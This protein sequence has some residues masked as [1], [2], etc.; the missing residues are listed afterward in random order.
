MSS[1]VI[2]V[3][4]YVLSGNRFSYH[5]CPRSENPRAVLIIGDLFDSTVRCDLDAK[6]A[7]NFPSSVPEIQQDD[8]GLP[9]HFTQCQPPR[10][11]H[12]RV[13]AKVAGISESARVS[14]SNQQAG[15][16]ADQFA[17]PIPIAAIESLDVKLK[18]LFVLP[19]RYAWRY[20]SSFHQRQFR[21]ATIEGRLNTTHCRIHEP[22]DF[23]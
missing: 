18:N 4:N 1:S 23:L 8:R 7:L 3:C 12:T 20:G 6:N 13:D 11:R 15:I 5:D 16:S 9:I 10:H 19:G 22:C 14:I 17:E 21:P 2:R